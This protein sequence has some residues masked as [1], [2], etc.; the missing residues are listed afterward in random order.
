MGTQIGGLVVKEEISLD[1]LRQR[2]VGVD[3][4]NVIYQFLSSIRGPDG[5]PLMD[6]N[7]N[8]TSHL[9]GLLYRTTNL[10]E[11]GIKPVFV[12]DGKPHALKTKTI[13]ERIK[14]RTDAKKK[15][16]KALKEGNIVDAKKFGSRALHLTDKMVEQSKELLQYMGLPVIQAPADGEAQIALMTE[17]KQ[18]DGCVS[19]DY[20][21]LLFGAPIVFRNITVSGKR[22][23][24]GKN[25]YID[26]HPEKIELQKSLDFLK[27]DRKKLIWIAILVGTDFNE[28]FPKIGPKTALDLVQ[29][30]DSFEE[31]IKKTKFEPEFD[32]KE[33]EGIFL[34]PKYLED[35]KIEFK[36]PMREKVIEFLCEKHD[37]S[38]ERVESA[39]NKLEQKAQEKGEQKRLDSWFG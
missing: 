22:K 7:G 10:L 30:H 27:I 20:D 2:K 1:F 17:K 39:L 28:K 19:Q 9:T 36:D 35:F 38:K 24:P 6:S 5:T 31:I 37:F 34:N 11:K 23:V 14:I 26:V 16:E 3:A 4:Y 8:I 21:S 32:F 33:I 15:H 29:K 18:V 25:I 12:F 13:E